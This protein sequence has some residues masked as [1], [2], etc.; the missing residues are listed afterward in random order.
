MSDRIY[1]TRTD[2]KSLQLFGNNEF[3]S[4]LYKYLKKHNCEIDEDGCF[5]EHSLTNLD[6]LL[7]I[8]ESSMQEKL[9]MCHQA[10][11]KRDFFFDISQLYKKNIQRN[12]WKRNN[13]YQ[14]ICKTPILATAF[15]AY[16]GH[17][18]FEGNRLLSFLEPD[19]AI[20]MDKVF[21]SVLLGKSIPLKP[22]SNITLSRY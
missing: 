8:V 3:P 7:R 11:S 22:D 6:E 14:G 12:Q 16:E 1:I 9:K 15:Q 10:D 13:N 17:V 21:L 4:S 2:G 5:E 18:V 20:P 19:I